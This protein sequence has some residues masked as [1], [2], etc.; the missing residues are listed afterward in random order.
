[1]RQVAGKIDGDVE[2]SDALELLGMI[3]G[4]VVVASGGHLVLRGT[5]CAG[6]RIEP[7]GVVQLDGTVDGDVLNAGGELEVRGAI[8]GRLHAQA[9][10]TVV[11]TDAVI[12]GQR[13]P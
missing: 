10:T 7:G 13:Q 12:D 3:T 4:H 5:C 1:M 6:M 9:G 2:L 8:N 11:H